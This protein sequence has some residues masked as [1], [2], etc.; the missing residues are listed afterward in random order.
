MCYGWFVVVYVVDFS[1]K[2]CIEVMESVMLD[3]WMFDMLVVGMILFNDGI[4]ILYLFFR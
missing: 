2:N 3:K 4:N 1:V